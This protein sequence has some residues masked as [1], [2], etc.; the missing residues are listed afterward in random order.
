MMNK[1]HL[2]SSQVTAV[3]SAIYYFHNGL[4]IIDQVGLPEIRGGDAYGSR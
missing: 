4:T 3:F 2:K 1:R